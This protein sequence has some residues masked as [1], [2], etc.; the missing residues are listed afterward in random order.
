[1][2]LLLLLA[3][4]ALVGGCQKEPP[5]VL[6]LVVDA[7]RA[8]HVGCYG[9]IRDTT[10]NVDALAAQATVFDRAYSV[11]PWTTPSMA[12]LFTSLPPR[13]HG[14]TNWKQPLAPERLTISEH[15]QHQGYHTIGVV[16]HLVFR[17]T[18][19]FHQGYDFYDFSVLKKGPSRDVSTAEE[20]TDIMIRALSER[21][22]DKPFFAWAH[23]FDPHNR[24]MQ[25]PE[26]HFG[27]KAIDRYDSEIAFADHHIG[28]LLD[29]IREQQLD[30]NTIIVFTA[31]HGEEFQDHGGSM[32]TKTLYEEVLRIPLIIHAPGLKPGRVN[33]VVAQS[34]IAPT[35]LSLARLPSPPTFLGTPLEVKRKAFRH[36]Q[37]QLVIAET[38]RYSDQRAVI[39]GRWKL[40]EDR[41]E[42]SL[43]L[44][45]LQTDPAEK[46]NLSADHGDITTRL[47]RLLEEHYGSSRTQAKEQPVPEEM[48]RQLE[49]LGYVVEET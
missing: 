8:D 33:R 22:T 19:G 28:R 49:A 14:I 40:I 29:W 32:H 4:P 34:S 12:T 42:E 16:S 39:D 30:Q 47:R 43:L 3:V 46:T 45:D 5:N 11:A 6:L 27:K 15:M 38:L 7:L 13:E 1:L 17:P 44:F 41:L 36:E 24:Y 9:Y 48:K 20:V 21:P 2:A 26:F 25:H 37:D 18:R 31:D 35:I 10:P 23:Y